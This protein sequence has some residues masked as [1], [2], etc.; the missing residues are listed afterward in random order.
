LRSIT[1]LLRATAPIV[2]DVGS[3]ATLI[4]NYKPGMAFI[5]AG[6]EAGASP[7]HCPDELKASWEWNPS[8]Q[9]TQQEALLRKYK[10]AL[11]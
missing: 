11:S 6:V 7:S 5:K 4:D 1:C 8:Q 3:T 9:T 10:Q 2:F